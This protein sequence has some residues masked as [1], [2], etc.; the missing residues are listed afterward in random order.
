[1]P[2]ITDKIKPGTLLF[3]TVSEEYAIFLKEG[4][5]SNIIIY[6]IISK[7]TSEQSRACWEVIKND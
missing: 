6:W 2:N 1:M 5:D 7:T 4:E 3:C